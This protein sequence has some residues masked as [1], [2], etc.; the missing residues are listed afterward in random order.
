MVKR[1]GSQAKTTGSASTQQASEIKRWTLDRQADF[2]AHLAMTTNVRASAEAVGMS[3]QG[4]YRLRWRSP[5]FK[6]AWEIAKA[7]GYVKLEWVLLNRAI[8]GVDKPVLKDGKQVGSVKEYS[9]RLGLSLLHGPHRA[10]H[11]PRAV[12]VQRDRAEVRRRI[13]ARLSEMNKRMGGDG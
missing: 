7:E 12:E 8:E 1:A 11:R 5:A 4:T 13:E 3:E 6:E 9:D 10:T 2:L